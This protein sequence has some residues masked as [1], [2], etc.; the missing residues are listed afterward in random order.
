MKKFFKEFQAFAL[1]G[2]VMNLAVGVIIGN[3]F[4]GIVTSLVSDIIN[5]LLSLFTDTRFDE[6][7]FKVGKASIQYGAFISSIINFFI[8]AFVIFSM[9]KALNKLDTKVFK[10][11]VATEATTKKCP[12]CCS[13]IPVAATRCPDCTSELPKEVKPEIVE[14][15]LISTT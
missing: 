2:N 10:N 12:F 4:Q 11:N 14:K 1:R 15:P 3:A 13:E 5:P 7:T 8:M 6:L 9:I